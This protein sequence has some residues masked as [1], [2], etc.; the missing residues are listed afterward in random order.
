MVEA[1]H[2]G[3]MLPATL[4]ACCLAGGGD[5]RSATA[6]LG[7]LAMLA[8]MTDTMV[9]PAP[10][11][12]PVAWA[13]LLVVLAIATAARTRPRTGAAV[14]RE[15]HPTMGLHRALQGLLMAGLLL[16]MSAHQHAGRLVTQATT[17]AHAAHAMGATWLPL[18]LAGAALA[19]A[20]YSARLLARRGARRLD[21]AEAAL[22]GFAI[23]AMTVAALV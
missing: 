18:A 4:G 8:A 5:R 15:T 22:G 6:W 13:A 10:L 3:S 21:R 2:L 20:A 14:A 17:S 19:F 9:L 16:V 12:P 23:A 1:L 11:L 7:M